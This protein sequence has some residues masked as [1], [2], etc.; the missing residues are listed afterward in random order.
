MVSRHFFFFWK[1]TKKL[2]FLFDVSTVKDFHMWVSIKF[3][4]GNG[5]YYFPNFPP[6]TKKKETLLKFRLGYVRNVSVSFGKWQKLNEEL[7]TIAFSMSLLVMQRW[8]FCS[9][10]PCF[11]FFSCKFLLS[12]DFS[13]LPC[14]Y[15]Y[16]LFLFFIIFYKTWKQ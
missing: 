3:T 9:P 11:T 5:V 16:Y 2:A 7:P 14:N 12:T 13:F 10:I 15:Y 1:T 8:L 6:S 4:W